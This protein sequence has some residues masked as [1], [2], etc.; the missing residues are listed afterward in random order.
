MKNLFILLMAVFMLASCTP[1]PEFRQ[2]MTERKFLRQNRDAVIAGLDGPR[3]I[4]RVKREDRFF[5]LATFEG[6][7]LVSLEERE[8]LPLWMQGQQENQ[9]N[10]N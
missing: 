5:V 4:Y 1:R 3:T 7:R 6:G 9:P 2:G 8:T 10:E